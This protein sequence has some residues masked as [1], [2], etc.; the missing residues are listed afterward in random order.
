VPFL[1]E[2]FGTAPLSPEQWLVCVAMASSVLWVTEL[3]KLAIRL[4]D[5]PRP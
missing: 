1:N 2:A 5:R 4:T 3:R